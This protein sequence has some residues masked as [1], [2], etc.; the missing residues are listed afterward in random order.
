VVT[1][2]ELNDKFAEL[3]AEY[4][5]VFGEMTYTNIFMDHEEDIAIMEKALAT[6]EPYND[7]GDYPEGAI[8]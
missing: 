8:I 4:I 3:Q 6:G 2:D 1:K 7:D 5:R